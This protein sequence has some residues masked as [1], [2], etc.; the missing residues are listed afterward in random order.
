[1]QV[2]PVAISANGRLLAMADTRR[3]VRISEIQREPRDVCV[4]E[5]D[6]GSFTSLAFAPDGQSLAVAGFSGLNCAVQLWDL[7]SKQVKADFRPE[8]RV[9]RVVCFSP[10][11]K[12][13]A[14]G[15]GHEDGQ[16]LIDIWS[17]SKKQ[18]LAKLGGYKFPV[19]TIAFSPDGKVLAGGSGDKTVKLWK[20]D[21]LLGQSE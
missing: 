11:G 1:L 10:N 6:T 14:V 19:T 12:L 16:G 13:L 8:D 9:V 17:I 3:V 4:L 18:Q 21:R 2:R 5:G 20:L 15:G 7:S